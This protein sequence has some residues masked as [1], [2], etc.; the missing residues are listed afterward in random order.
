MRLII[1]AL[2]GAALATAPAL[3][4]RAQKD[5][6]PTATKTQKQSKSK[7]ASEGMTFAKKAAIGNMYEIQAGQLAEQKAQRN[8]VKQAAQMIVSDHQ[9]AGDELKQTLGEEA[10]SLPTALDSK[11]AQL[12]NQLKKASGQQ[13]DPLYVRQQVQAHQ[14]TIALFRN[15]AKSGQ[16][17]ELKQFAETTLPTLEKHLKEVQELRSAA[18]ATAQNKGVGSSATGGGTGTS[19]K[20]RKY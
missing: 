17:A 7:Q 4:Q 15:Y 20:S 14:E 13:F 9:K 18:P 11:H 2:I 19:G 6:H 1:A 12:L 5:Q 16:N 10:S 8:D 3:A